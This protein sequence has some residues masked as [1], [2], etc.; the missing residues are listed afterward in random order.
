MSA[1]CGHPDRLITYNRTGADGKRY[2]GVGH[3]PCTCGQRPAPQ[4][5]PQPKGRR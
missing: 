1:P 5:E 3:E 4:P 2:Q